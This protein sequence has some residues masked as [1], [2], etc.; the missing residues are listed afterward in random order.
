M[1]LMSYA[2]GCYKSSIES[3]LVK[4][5]KDILRREITVDDLEWLNTNVCTYKVEG[6]I[7]FLDEKTVIEEGL[8][9]HARYA[10]KVLSN[11]LYGVASEPIKDILDLGR[12]V[13]MGKIQ[14]PE[15]IVE[16]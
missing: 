9:E 14:I 6:V 16:D 8:Y 7:F 15:E 13:T 11:E 4:S 5:V 10:L 1:G 3:N 2:G 12:L